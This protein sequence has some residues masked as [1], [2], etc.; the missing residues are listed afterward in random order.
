MAPPVDRACERNRKKRKTE[1]S[2]LQNRVS[3]S[4]AMSGRR[5]KRLSGS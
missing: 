5:R 4:R 3:M 2:E 1:R